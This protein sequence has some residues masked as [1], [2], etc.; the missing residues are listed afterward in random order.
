[1]SRFYCVIILKNV[2]LQGL[3]IKLVINKIIDVLENG[4]ARKLHEW[5]AFSTVVLI[6]V[7]VSTLQILMG[8]YPRT[9]VVFRAVVTSCPSVS[10]VYITLTR[11]RVSRGSS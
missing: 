6:T 1:M 4:F 2:R 8:L 11:L 10:D 5:L 3:V 7:S 9:L